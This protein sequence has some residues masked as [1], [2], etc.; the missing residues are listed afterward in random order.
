MHIMPLA[1]THSGTSLLIQV[2]E[3]LGEAA[4]G[5]LSRI[6]IVDIPDHIEWYIHDYDGMESVHEKH[7]IWS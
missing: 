2:I 1:T 5:E 4:N 7:A 6:K 3:E